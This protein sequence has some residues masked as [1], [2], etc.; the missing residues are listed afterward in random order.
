MKYEDAAKR[1]GALRKEM[2][3][4]RKDMQKVRK[5]AKPQKVEDYTL[6]RSSGEPVKLSELF[7]GKPYLFMIHNMGASC[8]YCTLWADGFNGLNDHLQNSAAFVVSSPDEPPK[9]AK[10]A[11]SRGWKFPMVSHKGTSFA[12]DLGYASKDG[13]YPGVS[14]LTRKNGDIL[15]VSDEGLSPGD[16]FCSIWHFLELI[17]GKPDWQPKFAY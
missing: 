4:L 7:G 3:K 9:Q 2:T 15:R 6:A 5:A 13:Y 17:P 14:V 10:F 12:Q 11:S 16:D 1:L 8:P